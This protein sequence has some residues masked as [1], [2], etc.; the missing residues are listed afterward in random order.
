MSAR[1]IRSFDEYLASSEQYFAVVR[2]AGD[3]PW[4]ENKE[5]AAAMAARLGLPAD[6]PPLELRRA[7]WARGRSR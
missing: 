2:E 1:P 3:E 6:T 5:R 4:F 7:L